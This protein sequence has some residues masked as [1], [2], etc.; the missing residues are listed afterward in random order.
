MP[1]KRRTI[2]TSSMRKNSKASWSKWL[3]QKSLKTALWPRRAVRKVI[4]QWKKSRWPSPITAP[5]RVRAC[6]SDQTLAGKAQ[7]TTTSSSASSVLTR[8]N[9]R[10]ARPSLIPRQLLQVCSRPS[11]PRRRIVSTKQ[12]SKV[13]RGSRPIC[14]ELKGSRNGSLRTSFTRSSRKY[15]LEMAIIANRN[16]WSPPQTQSRALLSTLST[17]KSR[18]EHSTNRLCLQLK[19]K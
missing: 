4:N 3:A 13:R 17:A 12:I 6:T 10:F 2:C 9:R 16:K 5:S 7:L 18:S 1:E 19:T 8:A 15:S 11:L 14:R